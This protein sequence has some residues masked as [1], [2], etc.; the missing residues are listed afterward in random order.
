VITHWDRLLRASPDPATAVT[1][2]ARRSGLPFDRIDHLREV[3]NFC[4][5]PRRHGW[6]SQQD[7]DT[8]NATA[9]ELLLR[10]AT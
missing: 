2:L 7:V 3:R 6:P 10:L 8:A 1:Y 5:H 9:Q 4:A